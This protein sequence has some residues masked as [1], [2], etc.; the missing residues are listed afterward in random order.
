[1]SGLPSPATPPEPVK[2]PPRRRSGWEW[3]LILIFIGAF[4]L[5]QRSTDLG[6][7]NWWAFF[8]LLP[9]F[10]S[11]ARTWERYESMDKKITR[12]VVEPFM[13]GLFFVAII[14]IFLF[15]LAWGTVL[16]FC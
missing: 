5:L 4:V 1:M 14:L 9:A 11:P 3:G 2:P 7:T 16:R 6:I 8:I 10:G 15:N 13:A 12:K